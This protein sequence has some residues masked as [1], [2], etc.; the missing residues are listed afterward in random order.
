[1][2]KQQSSDTVQVTC[3]NCGTENTISRA[4][5][6]RYFEGYK[7]PMPMMMGDAPQRRQQPEPPRCRFCRQWLF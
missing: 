7:P 5:A 4:L 6:K 3:R 1:M 2:P